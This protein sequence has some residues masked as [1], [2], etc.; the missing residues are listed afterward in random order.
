MQH[1]ALYE[2][3]NGVQRRDAKRMLDEYGRLFRWRSDGRDSLL[4]IGCGSADVTIDYVLPL[5]PA[6]YRRLV[7]ADLSPAM[8]RFARK[9]YATDERIAFERIDI[10]EPLMS[11]AGVSASDVEPGNGVPVVAGSVADVTA[12]VSAVSSA[13]AEWLADPFDHI[14][15]FYCLHWVQNQRQAMQNVYDLL[16]PGGDC[17]HVFLATN[18]IFDV[19]F[20]LGKRPRWASFLH[21]A[22]KFMTPYQKSASPAD[23]MGAHLYAAGFSE[24]SVQLV[25]MEYVYEG[26]DVLRSKC[27]SFPFCPVRLQV[28]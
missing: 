5:L 7:G 25:D 4:D 19:Y 13:V 20:E 12:G 16:A 10:G 9:M 22:S 18:I 3:A 2:R 14:T 24:Y 6:T 8:L 21:D 11:V 15:S 1:A 23:E 17:L 26:L 27:A 28:L